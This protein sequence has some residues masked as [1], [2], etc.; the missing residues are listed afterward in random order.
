MT[1]FN[2]AALEFNG[3]SFSVVLKS[4]YMC[5]TSNKNRHCN[6]D[7]HVVL[8]ILGCL[9]CQSSRVQNGRFRKNWKI[10]FWGFF[11]IYWRDSSNSTKIGIANSIPILFLSFRTTLRH[12]LVESNMAPDDHDEYLSSQSL[13]VLIREHLCIVIIS[14]RIEIDTEILILMLF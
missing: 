1:E 6:F 5:D 4:L 13:P 11:S 12:N 7:F 9:N 10:N 14:K 2:M 3:K 8:I